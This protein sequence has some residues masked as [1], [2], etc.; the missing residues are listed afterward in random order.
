MSTSEQ[1]RFIG[2]LLDKTKS[3]SL[4]WKYLSK[5]PSLYRDPSETS[6]AIVR[7]MLDSQVIPHKSFYAEFGEMLI[8]VIASSNSLT[9]ALTALALDAVGPIK[10]ITQTTDKTKQKIVATTNS[11]KYDE[12]VIVQL[13]RLYNYLESEVLNELDDL[14]DDFMNS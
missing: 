3:G 12:E 13:K 1:L 6:H 11:D 5:N 2:K 14:M 8:F 7:S 10:L 4:K 9:T